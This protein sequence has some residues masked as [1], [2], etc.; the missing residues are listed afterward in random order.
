[1]EPRAP[2]S[3]VVE[4]IPRPVR[5]CHIRLTATLEV[6]GFEG[7]SMARA[8][9]SRPDPVEVTSNPGV[10]SSISP[11]RALATGESW[12][13]RRRIHSSS[14]G[15]SCM[16][17]IRGGARMSGAIS[18]ARRRCSARIASMSEVASGRCSS[19]P[20]AWIQSITSGSDQSGVEE[21]SGT[22]RRPGSSSKAIQST[23]RRSSLSSISSIQARWPRYEFVRMART[24]HPPET[25]CRNPSKR[26]GLN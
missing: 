5:W 21:L 6:N 25:D 7:S 16:T 15:P 2:K 24:F 19:R 17:R 22:G 20:F 8:S 9:S 12:F 1:M 11:R 3:S 10:T 14:A 26:R 13:P 4:T 18:R 23:S